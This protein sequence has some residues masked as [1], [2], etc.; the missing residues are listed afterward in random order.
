MQFISL[1]IL[2][3]KLTSKFLKGGSFTTF[4]VTTVSV[5][6]L[7]ACLCSSV[8]AHKNLKYTSSLNQFEVQGKIG[9]SEGKKGG[10]ANFMWM[11]DGKNFDIRLY[12]PFG[13]GAV[14]IQNESDGLI[15]LT[16]AEGRSY[17]GKDAETLLIKTTG[18]DIP[19]SGLRY[20][21][22]GVPAPYSKP[23]DVVFSK[24]KGQLESFIQDGWTVQYQGY[25]QVKNHWVP[26]A[27]TLHHGNIRLKVIFKRW[28]F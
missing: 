23:E 4:S 10:S 17:S 19:V 21:L 24:P 28:D 27:L 6:V 15:I 20:W 26:K 1:K 18:W 2:S 13:A 12:G 22:K 25:R 16:D 7:L 8:N 14:K 11:E 5:F 3:N 9:F